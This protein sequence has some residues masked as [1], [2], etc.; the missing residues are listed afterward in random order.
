MAVTVTACGPCV[1]VAPPLF[2]F[3]IRNSNVSLRLSLPPSVTSQLH[4]SIFP[5]FALSF[6]SRPYNILVPISYRAQQPP[7]LLSR[8]SLSF[9]RSF[10]RLSMGASGGKWLKSL[11]PH[12][13]SPP[14]SDQVSPHSNPPCSPCPVSLLGA[15]V[16]FG[17][18]SR[19]A[20]SAERV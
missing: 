16:M 9:V 4:A 14:S 10:V 18:R 15:L 2:P 12:R 6:S 11:L 1:S 8:G 13:K 7:L 5:L 19:A 20:P 17:P 3:E